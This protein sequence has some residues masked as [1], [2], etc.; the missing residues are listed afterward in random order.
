MIGVVILSWLWPKKEHEIDGIFKDSPLDYGESQV[1]CVKVK[2]FPI[3]GVNQGLLVQV[4]LEH[5]QTLVLEMAKEI[6]F[7]GLNYAFFLHDR[8]ILG[9]V[10]QGGVRDISDELGYAFIDGLPS[11]VKQNSFLFLQEPGTPIFDL[12]EPHLGDSNIKFFNPKK[13]ME[14]VNKYLESELSKKKASD[15]NRAR[16]EILS[17]LVALDLINQAEGNSS[18]DKDTSLSTL[19]FKIKEAIDNLGVPIEEFCRPPIKCDE[20]KD[21][22]EK[23]REYEK[24]SSWKDYHKEL[25]GVAEG[26]EEQIAAIEP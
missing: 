24:Y 11:G 25:K 22:L 5:N 26:M 10:V 6:R 9:E 17:P 12:L 8:H 3:I 19:K 21:Q 4:E 13:F 14:D 15:V 23:L 7:E 18:S 20:F 2:G 1:N 16:F